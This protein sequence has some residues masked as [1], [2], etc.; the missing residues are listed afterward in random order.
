MANPS[1]GDRPRSA[2][3]KSL[4]ALFLAFLLATD[5]LRLGALAYARF[6]A[7]FAWRHAVD[8]HFV[9]I[10]Q[11]RGAFRQ[12]QSRTGQRTT[13]RKSAMFSTSFSGIEPAG[14][15]I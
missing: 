9:R 12:L 10:R 7:L 3:A 15:S 14:H 11:Q 13:K 1:R 2:G 8:D 6:F 4:L 5:Q